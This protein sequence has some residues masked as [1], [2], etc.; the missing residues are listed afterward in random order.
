MKWWD[1][2]LLSNHI[3]TQEWPQSLGH[4]HTPIGLLVV[5]DDRE[6]RPPHRQSAAIQRVDEFRLAL[7]RFALDLR[8]ARLKSFEVR[9][10]RDLFI[11]VLAGEP[12]LQVIRFRRAESSVRGAQHHATISQ[13]Q[14]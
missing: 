10:R 12:D 11:I 7:A 6:P 13:P 2:R 8:A 3:N 5:L 4:H 9:A 1:P 14:A